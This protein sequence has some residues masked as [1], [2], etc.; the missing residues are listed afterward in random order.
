MKPVHFHSHVLHSKAF[1]KIKLYVI[2]GYLDPINTYFL[3]I[4]INSF[5]GDPSYI[6]S[7]KNSMVLH[8]YRFKQF[9]VSFYADLI[10]E[11]VMGFWT[12]LSEF[13]TFIN[14]N[15]VYF[16]L[17]YFN[18]LNGSDITFKNILYILGYFNNRGK[19]ITQ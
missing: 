19:K 1:I 4:K 7:E 11:K 9:G 15:T 3:I 6:S 13:G 8:P 5:Q 14:S 2:F 17:S 12:V 16:H 10:G 18:V